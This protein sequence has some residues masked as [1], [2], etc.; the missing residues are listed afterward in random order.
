MRLHCNQVWSRRSRFIETVVILLWSTVKLRSSM[1]WAYKPN[2]PWAEAQLHPKEPKPNSLSFILGLLSCVSIDRHPWRPEIDNVEAVTA[3]VVS[4]IGRPLVFM[5]NNRAEINASA[6]TTKPH[7]N[8]LAPMTDG[9]EPK[10]RR[11]ISPSGRTTRSLRGEVVW[12][13]H[14]QP[15]PSIKRVG[16][17]S[18]YGPKNFKAHVCNPT[19]RHQRHDLN[20]RRREDKPSSQRRQ[21]LHSLRRRILTVHQSSRYPLNL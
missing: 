17:V 16:Q 21:L 7:T 10:R 20:H 3:L 4:P 11:S 15:S 13:L 19:A 8:R 14:L 9:E 2:P 6:L 1:C 5:G 18:I 12:D